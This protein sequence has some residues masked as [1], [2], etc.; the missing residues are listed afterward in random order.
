VAVSGDGRRAV[1][2]SDDRTLKVWDLERGRELR[3]LSGHSDW[4]RDV[5]VS[6]DGRRAVSASEDQTLKVWDLETGALVTTFTCDAAAY[7]CAVSGA[8]TIVAGDAGG[9]VH[10]LSLEL[11]EDN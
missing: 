2:A 9:R 4:V 11:R 3:T 6:G 10:F 7:C 5:A 1:S 8:R